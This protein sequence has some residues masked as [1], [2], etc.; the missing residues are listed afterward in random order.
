MASASAAYAALQESPRQN[1]AHVLPSLGQLQLSLENEHR[2]VE[3]LFTNEA[4][5]LLSSY[6]SDKPSDLKETL[7][8]HE[9]TFARLTEELTRLN[10]QAQKMC[11]AEAPLAPAAMNAAR[12]A[13]L[14]QRLLRDRLD[15]AVPNMETAMKLRGIVGKLYSSEGNIA[16]ELSEQIQKDL[17]EARQRASSEYMPAN[18]R[19]MIDSVPAVLS[20]AAKQSYD[21]AFYDTLREIMEL[22]PREER[23]EYAQG[24]EASIAILRDLGA[25]AQKMEEESAV[26]QERISGCSGRIDGLVHALE[27]TGASIKA[28][29]GDYREL[30]SQAAALSYKQV[31]ALKEMVQVQDDVIRTLQRSGQETDLLRGQVEEV[32]AV[33]SQTQRSSQEKLS[34]VTAERDAF[35][36]KAQAFQNALTN[37]DAWVAT[38]RVQIAPA[39]AQP[40][41]D[42]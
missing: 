10:E 5:R 6:H 15:A 29:L 28:A 19:S 21:H 3:R 8:R 39:A 14:C 23:E 18:V 41:Q 33:L 26:L 22:F 4:N 37:I 9:R 40:A 12:G 16:P 17:S 30:Q 31:A 36:Q 32:T 35:A 27:E 34:R 25:S 42:K 7:Q 1:F 24:W 38:V 2:S 20:I 13:I 11:Q